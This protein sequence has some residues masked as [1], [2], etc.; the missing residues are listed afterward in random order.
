MPGESGRDTE[1]TPQAIAVLKDMA[2]ETW[3]HSRRIAG[4]NANRGQ[5][6]RRVHGDPRSTCIRARRPMV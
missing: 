6:L 3:L 1:L 4:R 5:G 2:G